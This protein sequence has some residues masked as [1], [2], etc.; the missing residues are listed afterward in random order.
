MDG[1]EDKMFR[2]ITS[3]AVYPTNSASNMVW[4]EKGHHTAKVEFRSSGGT[5]NVSPHTDYT[6][7]L[8]SV[9]YYKIKEKKE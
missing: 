6:A 9:E 5:R 3:N 1:K 2:V 7:Y 8:F 4:L